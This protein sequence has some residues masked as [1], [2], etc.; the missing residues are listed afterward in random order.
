MAGDGK[1]ILIVEDEPFV[2][3][4]YKT[5]LSKEGFNVH[6]AEDGERGWQIAQ[7]VKPDLIL[8]DL[9]LP[10][11]NGFGVLENLKSSE[12]LKSIPV[13]ILSNLGQ[14][15]D[16]QKGLDLGAEDYLV[17]SDTSL[18]EVLEKIESFIN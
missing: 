18:K 17:K 5:K 16:I 12:E 2:V 7:E 10:K 6:V 11:M 13:L 14:Q 9:I 3:N 4:V 8:L 15:S 1:D